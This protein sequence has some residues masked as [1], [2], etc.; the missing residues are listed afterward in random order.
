[1]GT[2]IFCR[3]AAGERPAV[4]ILETPAVLAFLDIAPVHPGHTLV[5]PRAHYENLLDLPDE[6]WKEMGQVCRRLGR[7][8]RQALKAEGFNLGMNNFPAAG[9]AVFHAHIHMVPRYA[10]DGLRLFPQWDYKP[11]EAEETARRLR[12]ALAER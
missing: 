3:I 11:G 9:Q 8:L 5:I 1:M 2:C 10:G 4:K 12:R 7:A 6:V